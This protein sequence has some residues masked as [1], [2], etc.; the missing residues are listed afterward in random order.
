MKTTIL[1]PA[2]L[3]DPRPRYSQ[4]IRVDS[5]GSL[6]FIA[7]QTA[8]DEHGQVVGRGDI[9]QQSERVFQNLAA[10]L[11]AAGASFDNLVMTTTYLTDLRYREAYNTVRLKYYGR[12]PPTN[13]LVIVQGLGHE[14]LLIEVAG[15]A[16]V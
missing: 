9:E 12:T 2:S 3:K 8:S 14:D 7:G 16:V 10:V 1:Q 15:I 11:T 6:V 13:T 5:G 4:G